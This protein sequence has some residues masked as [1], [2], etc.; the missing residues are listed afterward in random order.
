MNVLITFL[1]TGDYKEVTYVWG[2]GAEERSVCTKFFPLAAV[3]IFQPDDVLLLVTREVREGSGRERYERLC[4]QLGE[5]AR[6]V[7]IPDG[8]SEREVWEILER[9]AAEVRSDSAIILDVTHAFRS[10]GLSAF[11]IAA[12][13]R[14]ARNVHVRRIIYGAYEARHP[15]QESHSSGKDRAPI[16][17]LTPLLDLVDWLGAAEFFLRRSDATLLGER[18]QDIHQAAWQKRVGEDV[19]RKLKSVGRTLLEFSQALHLARP[20][21]VMDYAC[22]LARLLE[23]IK[24]EVECWAKPFEVILEQVQA[25]TQRLAHD[26]PKRLDRENLRK[27]LVL[28]EH[29]VDKGLFIQAVTL[30]REWVVS[31]IIL[32]RGGGNWLEREPREKI[33]KILALA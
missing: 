30:M 3:E 14:R 26:N 25:E 12:Y 19:P 32:Q 11:T 24:P 2:E 9:I 16:F 13:L 29:Y 33:G 20:L 17:D 22:K 4:Q 28:V 21:E 6:T 8:K 31:W 18:L 15:Q 27:Q 10:L 5:R 7:A 1:G 23:D